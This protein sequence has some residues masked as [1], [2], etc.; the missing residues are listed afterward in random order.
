[1]INNI[2]HYKHIVLLSFRLLMIVISF[3]F[4][5]I[6]HFHISIKLSDVWQVMNKSLVNSTDI[7]LTFYLNMYRL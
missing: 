3:F 7:Q 1:M 6:S 4:S 2:L 5:F